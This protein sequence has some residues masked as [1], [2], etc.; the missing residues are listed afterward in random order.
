MEDFKYEIN[1]EYKKVVDLVSNKYK[2]TD[3]LKNVLYKILPAMLDTASYEER[4][5]FYKML[6]HTP[7][8]IL[9]EGSGETS[10]TLKEKYIGNPNPHIKEE[11]QDLGEYGLK[12]ADGA[13]V[14]E[15]VMSEDLQILGTKQFLYVKAFDTTKP[16]YGVNEKKYELFGT[17]INVSNLIHELGHAWVSENRPYEIKDGILTQRVGTAELKSKFEKVSDGVYSEQ[18]LSKVGLMIEEGLN[19]NMEEEALMKYLNITP[20][21]LQKLYKE[22]LIPSNYK[23]LLSDMTNHLTQKTSKNL[24]NRW[25]ILGDKSASDKLNKAMEKTD[26]YKNRTEMFKERKEK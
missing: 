4:L 19:T 14:T 5:L 7:I 1:K 25:R 8:A 21:K 17:G 24:I 2:Y 20:E 26:E 13:F 12:E 10:K 3:D 6:S 16:L 11:E 23:G 15:P 9:A 22:I 18:V